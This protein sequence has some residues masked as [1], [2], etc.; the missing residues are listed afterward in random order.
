[1]AGLTLTLA[2]ERFAVCRLAPGAPIP[3]LPLG[4]SLLALTLTPDELSLVI[5]E[6]DAPER[7]TVETGWRALKV[8]GPLDFGLTGILAS[9]TQPL[10]EA[11]LSVFAISTYDT[12]FLLVRDVTLGEALATLRDAGHRIA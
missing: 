2:P 4:R 1:M 3:P 11:G 9:L 5:P 6:P 10:A 7:A 8:A 12:D